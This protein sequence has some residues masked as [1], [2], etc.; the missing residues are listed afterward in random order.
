MRLLLILLLPLF[1]QGQS[2]Y[3]GTTLRGDTLTLNLDKISVII[4]TDSTSTAVYNSYT[5]YVFTDTLEEILAACPDDFIYVTS[6]KIQGVFTANQPVA[7]NKNQIDVIYKY[8]GTCQIRMK[9]RQYS[10]V[11]RQS[12]DSVQAVVQQHVHT[13]NTFTPTID[14]T[15]NVAASSIVSFSYTK[16]GAWVFVDGTVTIDP[17]ND[18]TT[19]EVQ[20]TF[21]VTSNITAATDCIGS[22]WAA[23][24]TSDL[25]RGLYIT[26]DAARNRARILLYPMSDAS[27]S[28]NISYKYRI[29]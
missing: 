15:I 6:S 26:G 24:T 22:G 14:S 9:S 1:L 2:V 8:Q 21:P 12:Y 11:V 25:F 7:V 4:D 20:L 17:T 16:L 29:R 3:S 27:S 5:T 13:T 10:L 23:N 18:S 28:Y 19:T